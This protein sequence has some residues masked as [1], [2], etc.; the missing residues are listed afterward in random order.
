MGKVLFGP[1]GNSLAFYDEGHKSTLES[2]KWV[3]SQGAGKFEGG[4]DLFE[5][6][7][8]QGFRTSTETAAEIGREFEKYGIEMSLH[9]PY[10]INF[11]NPDPVMYEKSLGYIKTGIKFMKAFGAKRMVFHP[12]SCGKLT[13]EEAVALIMERFKEFMPEIEKLLDDDMLICPETMGK[14]MQI[15]TYKEVIDF[16]TVSEK[17]IPTFDFG[18]INSL[19][20]GALKT[21]DDF[22]KIFDYCFEKLGEERT[23][24]AQIHF[25]KIQYGPKGEIKH[26]TFDDDIYGPDFE[27]LSEVLV[28][29]D[30]SCHIICESDGTQAKDSVIMK[31][32]YLKTLHKHLQ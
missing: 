20:Q 25:S 11:A 22:Q 26:L 31:D 6:S 32:I 3:K 19:T 14:M 28:K 10:F 29:N 12:G 18:H 15:G 7:F 4:L 16:C 1:A 21:S 17:L 2:P 5:Y 24:K 27:P 30:M 23:K 8:G 9:A 13:R